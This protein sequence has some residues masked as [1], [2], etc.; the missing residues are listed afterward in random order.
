[1]E[2]VIVDLIKKNA[3]LD[4]EI[5]SNQPGSQNQQVTIEQISQQK[6]TQLVLRNA[7]DTNQKI[8]QVSKSTAQSVIHVFQ[9]NKIVSNFMNNGEKSYST[10]M[11]YTIML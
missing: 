8:E 6:I 9:D 11:D 2:Y 7:Q 4:L 10:E 3:A 5:Y 1:M